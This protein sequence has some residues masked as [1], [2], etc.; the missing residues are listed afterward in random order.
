M[1]RCLTIDRNRT[2]PRVPGGQCTQ[3]PRHPDA[4]QASRLSGSRRRF[5]LQP[6]PRTA[7][8]DTGA[9]LCPAEG[10]ACATEPKFA[11]HTGEERGKGDR[12]VAEIRRT[13][14][15]CSTG[16]PAR[17]PAPTRD[18]GQQKTGLEGRFLLVHWWRSVTRARTRLIQQR[19]NPRRSLQNRGNPRRHCVFPP[20]PRTCVAFDGRG[21]DPQLGIRTRT[22][23][24]RP[25]GETSSRR[26]AVGSHRRRSV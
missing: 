13:E 17:N 8:A 2:R 15:P 16:K 19:G 18:S 22:T 11:H 12:T 1:L 5:L 24:A 3:A 7:I 25:T 26:I 20:R 4:A 9:S 6:G 23:T 21:F 10:S 14:V